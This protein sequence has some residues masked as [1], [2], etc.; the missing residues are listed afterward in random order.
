MLERKGS[1]STKPNRK[2]DKKKAKSGN[3]TDIRLRKLEA[4][5]KDEAQYP[6]IKMG[7]TKFYKKVDDG[8]IRIGGL[9]AKGVRIVKSSINYVWY[10]K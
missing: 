1:K 7:R 9:G 2:K 8:Q 6:T 5:K 4:K 10:K 3:K